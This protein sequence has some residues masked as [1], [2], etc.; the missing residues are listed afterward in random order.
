LGLAAFSKVII[1]E[2]TFVGGFKIT[3]IAEKYPSLK[4]FCNPD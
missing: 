4:E 1:N 2:I 3:E